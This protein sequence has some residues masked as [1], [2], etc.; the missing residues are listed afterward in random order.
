MEN[1]SPVI[2]RH[3]AI[4]GDFGPIPAAVTTDR[5][6][7]I[8]KQ[9]QV[10][11]IAKKQQGKLRDPDYLLRHHYWI[12]QDG[13]GFAQDLKRVLERSG[14]LNVER[15]LTFTCPRGIEWWICEQAVHF[16]SKY[17]G[18][19]QVMIIQHFVGTAIRLDG[20]PIDHPPEM[21]GAA[22]DA[23]R[24]KLDVA[25]AINQQVSIALTGLREH[26]NRLDGHDVVLEQHTTAL[27]QL[28]ERTNLSP[29]KMI[30][31]EFIALKLHVAVSDHQIKQ[32]GTDLSNHLRRSRP[33][34]DTD[35]VWDDHARRHV[36]KYDVS[37]L[38][39][40]FRDQGYPC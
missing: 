29:D 18:E 28:Q 2:V 27:A 7:Y 36:N 23:F 15:L 22:D 10:Q 38:E 25:L 16:A 1:N 13:N 34:W 8:A 19:L 11:Q 32:W 31:R 14:A 20:H 40:F 4:P 39:V 21:P 24:S 12:E 3:T 6:A 37:D 5:Y 26:E 9:S 35:K 17:D 30:M 33:G